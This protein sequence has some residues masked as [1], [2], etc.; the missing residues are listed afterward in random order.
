MGIS[1]ELYLDVPGL[2]D[3]FFNEDSRVAKTGSSLIGGALKTIAT[4]DFIHGHAHA[5]TAA[6]S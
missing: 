2:L 1:D 5:F 4:F 3:V 6:T